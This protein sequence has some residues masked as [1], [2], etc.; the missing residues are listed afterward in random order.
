VKRVQNATQLNLFLTFQYQT[1]ESIFK[2]YADKENVSIDK[3]CMEAIN[4]EGG[5]KIIQPYFTPDAL[6]F[7]GPAMIGMY[8]SGGDLRLF[9]PRYGGLV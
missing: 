8:F 5:P 7:N 6:K 9:Y 2:H 1:F 3:I 4:A